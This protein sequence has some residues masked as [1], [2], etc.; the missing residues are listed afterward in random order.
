MSGSG[1]PRVLLI[2]AGAMGSHH[3]RVI[4][5]SWRCELAA[6]A[7][8][9]EQRG[10]RLARRFNAVWKPEV[11]SLS[12]VDAVVVAAPT[13]LHPRIASD[14]LAQGIPLFVEKPLCASL[15]DCREIVDLALG[16]D[17]PLMCG[18][19]ERFNPPVLEALSRVESPQA[20]HAH[21]LSNYS[22]RMQAGVTWDLLVHDVDI[23]LRV[24]DEG[25]PKIVNAVTGYS[26]F[27]ER[28]GE[29]TVETELE[30][31]G[32]RTAALSASRVSSRPARQLTIFEENRT[33]VADLLNPSVT[34]YS[35]KHHRA[36]GRA[37]DFS[38]HHEVSEHMECSGYREPLAAQLDRFVDLVEGRTDARAEIRSILPSHEA[39]AAILDS[40]DEQAT[41]A[42]GGAKG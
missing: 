10:R 16:R 3:G 23:T 29:D 37:A 35:G 19:V 34:V 14:V 36:F 8:P 32:A 26:A 30:F 2:G 28:P 25:T 22:P 21:R 5:E 1:L 27:E 39:V 4:G 18:F 11:D 7:E 17:I 13:S 33:V 41:G 31:S 12:D 9:D 24:F 6:V 20:V 40:A 42:T 38:A 15:N